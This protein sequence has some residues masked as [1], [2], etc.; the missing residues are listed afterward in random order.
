MNV[1]LAAEGLPAMLIDFAQ[2]GPGF[3]MSD[4]AFHLAHS[5]SPDVLDNGGEE[6]L[7]NA[8]L[9]A[10]TQ[11]RGTTTAEYSKELAWWH[12]HLGVVDYGRFLIARFWS[13]A[14]PETFEKKAGNPNVTLPNRNVAAALRFVRRIDECLRKLEDTCN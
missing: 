3:G 1:L 14:S 11:A 2:T 7:V 12:Y 4:V 6:R 13:D 5:V 9:H 10:L 8:Y